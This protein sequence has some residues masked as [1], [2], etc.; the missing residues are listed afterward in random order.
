MTAPNMITARRF[1][2]ALRLKLQVIFAKA[3]EA[4][5]ETYRGQAAEFVQRVAAWLP[6]LLA[7]ICG[8]SPPTAAAA[9][10]RRWPNTRPAAAM[11]ACAAR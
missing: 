9:A 1:S 7:A 5:A 8:S 3:W 11:P 6:P 4:L 10:P 2:P